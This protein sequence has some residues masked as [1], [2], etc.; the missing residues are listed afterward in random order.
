ML[1]VRCVQAVTDYVSGS[2]PTSVEKLSVRGDGV[3]TLT[4]TATGVDIVTVKAT[5]SSLTDTSA[6]VR[7]QVMWRVVCLWGS[8]WL[9]ADLCLFLL[10]CCSLRWVWVPARRRSS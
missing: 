8:C 10:L 4:S 3:S 6:V 1:R 5:G 7:V 9:G 2:P